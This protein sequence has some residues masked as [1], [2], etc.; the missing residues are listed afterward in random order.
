MAIQSARL[1]LWRMFYSLAKKAKMAQAAL[2]CAIPLFPQAVKAFNGF[3]IK[4]ISAKATALAIIAR[5]VFLT[6]TDSCFSREWQPAR[7]SLI[8][9]LLMLI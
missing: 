7:L 2:F 5:F 8:R 1:K 9:I 6:A 4:Q 3:I